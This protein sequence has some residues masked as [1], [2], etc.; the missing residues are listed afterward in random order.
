M[1]NGALSLRPN[2]VHGIGVKG[3]GSWP[4]LKARDGRGG[5]G[6]NARHSPD[7]STVIGGPL[8]PMW[9][10]WYMGFPIGW[11]GLELLEMPKFRR[12]FDLHGRS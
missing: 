12:W 4:T 9:A 5:Q 11:T 10:E 1:R 2:V 6:K 7:L 8:S 3:F